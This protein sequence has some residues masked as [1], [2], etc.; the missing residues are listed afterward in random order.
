MSA[1]NGLDELVR[2]ANAEAERLR[3]LSERHLPLQAGTASYAL[4]HVTSAL[5][6][7]QRVAPGTTFTRSAE[8]LF[9]KESNQHAAW[10]VKS[11]AAIL[12]A[13][14][15][16]TSET[17]AQTLPFEVQSRIE[18]ATDLM[19][20]VQ[21]LLDEPK[22]H[23]AAPTVLAGAA[24]EEFLRSRV[25][26]MG[27]TPNGKP[28]INTYAAALQAAGDLSRQEVKDITA[29]AGRRNDAAHGDFDDLTR[30]SARLMVDGI[31]LFLQKRT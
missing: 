14:A 9:E 17:W 29:W 24:L 18:A 2:W 30:E 31:N 23:P 10:V 5:A 16:S 15:K 21:L 12:E 1:Q 26:A 22:V 8:T 13:W 7:L 28:G 11:M 6:F 4:Q 3:G 25:V 27:L 20:Q 19:E